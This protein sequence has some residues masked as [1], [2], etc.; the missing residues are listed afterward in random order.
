MIRSSGS[1][2]LSTMSHQPNKPNEPDQRDK[3][4]KP[5]KPEL[6]N[7]RPD[8]EGV[9]GVEIE[10]PRTKICPRMSLPQK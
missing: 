8:P 7:S 4:N 9:L 5:D 10:T 2:E 6:P 1:R 3:P